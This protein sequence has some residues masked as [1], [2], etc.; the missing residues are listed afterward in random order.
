MLLR[1]GTWNG[2]ALS[3]LRESCM[4]LVFDVL[5]VLTENDEPCRRLCVNPL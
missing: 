3:E 5:A 2:L 1:R 4:A